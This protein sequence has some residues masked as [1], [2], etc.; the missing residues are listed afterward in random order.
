MTTSDDA[1]R[2]AMRALCDEL[3]TAHQRLDPAGIK[4]LYAQ[5]PDGIHF[6]ERALAYD[7]A[8]VAATL[9][10]LAAS[11]AAL[12]LTP[13]EFR[14]GGSGA[15]G[16]FAVTFHARRVLPD[17]RVFELDGRLTAVAAKIDGRWLIVHDHASLPLPTKPWQ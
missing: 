8:Q 2:D 1:V 13:G 10:A 15:T 14:A 6:W 17:G 16:W 12:E 4:R 11:V 7:F 5:L 3:F 9:D